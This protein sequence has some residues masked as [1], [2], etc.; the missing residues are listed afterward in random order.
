MKVE[1]ETRALEKLRT[2]QSDFA[3]SIRSGYEHRAKDCISCTTPGACC[4]DAHF[5]NVR[6]TRLEA[7]A[8]SKVISD[9]PPEKHDELK[10]RIRQTIER[11][12]LDAGGPDLT[13]YAC[14][15]FEKGVGC[16]VH[17]LA[18]PLPCIAH[19]CYEAEKDLPPDEL[20]VEHEGLVARLNKMT[21]RKPAT[22]T[23]IPVA[24]AREL[25]D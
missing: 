5:V 3:R 13:T 4:L 24:V 10:D 2:L 6:I 11:Y 15:L 1:S 17:G 7:V 12:D 25:S 14:P 8:I 21:Y 16:L 18:K 22:Q 20:L 23:S 9:L 19:A